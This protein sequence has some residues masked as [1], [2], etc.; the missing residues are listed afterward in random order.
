MLWQGL[1][2]MIKLI[3]PSLVLSIII[4]SVL[5]PGTGRDVLLRI[6]IAL[7]FIGFLRGLRVYEYS[8]R[9]SH[10]KDYIIGKA[11]L[12]EALTSIANKKIWAYMIIAA[13]FCGILMAGV[14]YFLTP[15]LYKITGGSYVSKFSFVSYILYIPVC[16][17]LLL[18]GANIFGPKLSDEE[19]LALDVVGILNQSPGISPLEVNSPA[20]IERFVRGAK[21]EKGLDVKPYLWILS[22]IR[23]PEAMIVYGSALKNNDIHVRR[24][25][26]TYLSRIGGVDALQLLKERLSNETDLETR[27]LIDDSIAKLS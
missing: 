24:M 2:A 1:T 8:F 16:S 18:F 4:L 6:L 9:F 19:E 25:A 11:T 12:A 26:V 13:Y 14:F 17:V 7:P 15:L 27:Q 23:P 20:A 21:N 3:L 22:H 10:W 5:K